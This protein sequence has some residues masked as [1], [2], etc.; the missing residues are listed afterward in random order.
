MAATVDADRPAEPLKT[1]PEANLQRINILLKEYDTLRSEILQRT[2]AGFALPAIVTAIAG[3]LLSRIIEHHYYTSTVIV[4]LG[5]IALAVGPRFMNIQI[6]RC[7]TRV[8][9]IEERV[10]FLAQ[11]HLLEWESRWGMGAT[12]HHFTNDFPRA[13][14]EDQE[15]LRAS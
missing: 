1:I 6:R 8:Q 13:L 4:L 5:V 10:N 11:D 14:Q 12:G 15:V 3:W 9:Q 2:A 7:A